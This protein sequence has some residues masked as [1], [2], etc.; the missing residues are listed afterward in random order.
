MG[1]GAQEGM[2]R[3]L[4]LDQGPETQKRR[5]A[6]EQRSRGAGLEVNEGQWGKGQIQSPVHQSLEEF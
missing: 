3:G 6:E 5:D 4:D 2:V 1:Q